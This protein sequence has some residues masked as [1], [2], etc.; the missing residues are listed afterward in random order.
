M[1]SLFRGVLALAIA[2][3]SL[4]VSDVTNNLIYAIFGGALLGLFAGLVQTG[5]LWAEATKPSK[6]SSILIW[7]PILMGIPTIILLDLSVASQASLFVAW[8]LCYFPVFIW[9]EATQE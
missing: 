9:D 3:A 5:R 2:V 8:L 6:R 1:S 7:I 4:V